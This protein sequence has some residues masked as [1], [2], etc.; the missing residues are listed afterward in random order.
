MGSL[1]QLIMISKATVTAA[2]PQ[3]SGMCVHFKTA[4]SAQLCV[5]FGVITDRC[6]L[7]MPARLVL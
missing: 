1:M 5:E 7:S 2:E 4:V 6:V 3:A